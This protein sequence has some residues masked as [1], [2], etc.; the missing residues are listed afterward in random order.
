MF[1]R[2]QQFKH[3]MSGV[4]GVFQN[5]GCSSKAVG[6]E[7]VLQRGQCTSGDLLGGDDDF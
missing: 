7:N 5:V 3:M 1:A 6:A 2:G 4:R